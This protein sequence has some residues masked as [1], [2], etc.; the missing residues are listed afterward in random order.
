[1]S[2]AQPLEQ[3][4]AVTRRSGPAAALLVV[5]LLMLGGCGGDEAIESVRP[6][7]S[8]VQ[9]QAPVVR[10]WYP[11][12][13]HQTHAPA[14]VPF[15][16]SPQ[17]PAA[18]GYAA[19]TVGQ[20]AGQP[21]YVAPQTVYQVQPAQPQYPQAST[22]WSTPQPATAP[23]TYWS[24][25]VP[26]QPQMYYAPVARPWGNPVVPADPQQPAITT[27]SWPQSGYTAPWSV[28]PGMVLQPYNTVPGYGHVW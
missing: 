4:T 23:Q 5:S 19:P 15:V 12:P 18:S 20:W 24:A 25:P 13:K 14:Q 22:V 7:P 17:A 28:Q 10:E 27:E 6:E 1:M 8:T 3:S 16:A 21:V 2:I 26:V 11:S 9:E